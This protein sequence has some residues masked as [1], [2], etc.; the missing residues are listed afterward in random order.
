MSKSQ[1]L[2]VL[3]SHREAA[4]S[5]TTIALLNVNDTEKE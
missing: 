2:S 5:P 1:R 4:D 3:V